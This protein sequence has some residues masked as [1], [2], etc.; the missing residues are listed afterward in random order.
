METQWEREGGEEVSGGSDIMVLTHG[1]PEWRNPKLVPSGVPN[2]VYMKRHA[3]QVS[4]METLL[5]VVLPSAL[6]YLCNHHVG[7]AEVYI[8]MSL[9]VL[10]GQSLCSVYQ[11]PHVKGTDRTAELPVGAR[12]Q[13]YCQLFLY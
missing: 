7:K 5:S 3:C 11:G 13:E 6:T 9:Q 8:V 2:D 10:A 12:R 1:H 4:R